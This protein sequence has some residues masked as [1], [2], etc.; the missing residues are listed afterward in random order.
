MSN[1]PLNFE[2]EKRDD[3]TVKITATFSITFEKIQ[4]DDGDGHPDAR[5]EIT[6]MFFCQILSMIAEYT[7][8]KRINQYGNNLATVI[9]SPAMKE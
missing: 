5:N 4:T 6:L 7:E 8:M 9:T 3:G 1:S 2:E